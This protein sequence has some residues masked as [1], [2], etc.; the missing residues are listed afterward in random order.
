[1]HL[2]WVVLDVREADTPEE[3]AEAQ[4]C[5]MDLLEQVAASL[6]HKEPES[7]CFKLC[8]AYS[9]HGNHSTGKQPQPICK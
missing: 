5:A 1:M 7:K 8:G 3:T 9:L 2:L 4:S 6:P